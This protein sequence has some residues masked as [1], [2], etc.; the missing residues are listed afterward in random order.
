MNHSV[1]P[2]I[3]APKKVVDHIVGWLE[4]YLT[5]SDLNGFVVGVSGGIDSA[6]TSTLCALTNKKT[7]CVEMNIHQQDIQIQRSL[8]HMEWLA[9]Q[10]SN[11]EIQSINLTEVFEAFVKSVSEKGSE[12]NELSLANSR[13][14]L[15]MVTLYYLAGNH[16]YLVVG[17][18]NKVEDFGVGFFTKYGDGGVDISPI[19]DLL[20]S[21]VYQLATYL[22]INREILKAPPTDGLWH[23]NRTDQDQLGV[24]YDQLEWAM[25]TIS[26]KDMI[27]ENKSRRNHVLE[28]YQRFNS[29]NKHKMV[30]VPV[31][32]IPKNYFH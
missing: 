2:K 18:G 32:Y 3:N 30:P 6:L 13:S 16:R 8:R 19:A 31:C 28:T 27:T 1:V 23:D 29:S 20:K 17:T 5:Q 12:S 22:G 15:R 10:Y 26:R 11:V 14:R 25:E 9:S 24:S 4:N 7:I 21:H